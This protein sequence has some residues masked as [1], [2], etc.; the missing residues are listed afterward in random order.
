M[1]IFNMLRKRRRGPKGKRGPASPRPP[2]HVP[3]LAP[4]A[5]Y[6]RVCQLLEEG[7]DVRLVELPNGDMGVVVTRPKPRR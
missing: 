6:K 3:R 1:G 7:H 2:E 5:H 4:T